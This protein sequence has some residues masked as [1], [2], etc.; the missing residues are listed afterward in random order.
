V[1][2]YQAFS[3]DLHVP[4]RDKEN[5]RAIEKAEKKYYS[6]DIMHDGRLAPRALGMYQKGLLPP[7]FKH[8]DIKYNG[9]P[10]A[11]KAA[12]EGK[13]PASFKQWSLRNDTGIPVAHIAAQYGTLPSNFTK[14]E[15]TEEVS[16]RYGYPGR[17]VASEYRKKNGENPPGYDKAINE[18]FELAL[19]ELRGDGLP[20]SFTNWA[21][22]NTKKDKSERDGG[23]EYLRTI[24]HYAAEYGKLPAAFDQWDLK[25]AQGISVE[26]TAAFYGK[27]P[28][29]FP[30]E[31]L[32]HEVDFRLEKATIAHIAAEKGCLPKDFS[33]FELKDNNGDT[34]YHYLARAGR[35][36]ESF[37]KWDLKGG[38]KTVAQVAALHGKLPKDFDALDSC[39]EEFM[40]GIRI[41]TIESRC[42]DLEDILLESK[43][44]SFPENIPE[45]LLRKEVYNGLTV[46]HFAASQ[47]QLPQDYPGW[48]DQ[49]ADMERTVAHVA[50]RAD[51]LP[52][53]FDKWDLKNA[54]G[55]T[56]AHI[57]AWHANLPATF[58][59]WEMADGEGNAVAHIAAHRGGLPEN[60]D[61]WDLKN[62]A[63][64]TVAHTAAW[65][66]KLPATFDQWEMADG[67]G[68][69]VAHIT[70]RRGGLPENFDKW[71]LKN[72]AGDTVAHVASFYCVASGWPLPK[73]LD[74]W[75]MKNA[76]GETVIEAARKIRS[77]SVVEEAYAHATA[78][79]MVSSIH[80][81]TSQ[82]SYK[83][84]AQALKAGTLPADFND[85]SK[86]NEAGWTLAHAAASIGKLPSNFKD[87]SMEGGKPGVTVAHIAMRQGMLPPNFDQWDIKDAAGKTLGELAVRHP[88]M[89]AEYRG[90]I[91][92]SST[93]QQPR[94]EAR[95]PEPQAAK[96]SQEA[97][98]IE[99][100]S[101]GRIT[102]GSRFGRPPENVRSEPEPERRPVRSVI[103]RGGL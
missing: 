9:E 68:D 75:H 32:Y 18:N 77:S 70:A 49:S 38:S 53:N 8:W 27:L 37:D 60:F 44:V 21:L 73:S 48:L 3:K 13:L 33:D 69:A 82:L 67:K 4:Y 98:K 78:N 101:I 25:T 96:P 100:S 64:E 52:E 79:A 2:D 88:T 86:K 17:N 22:A 42:V 81:S 71:D 85:W 7:D 80:G 74:D 58:D 40:R 43:K 55:E 89:G 95:S 1:S 56:V 29:S 20:S 28:D 45:E 54:A 84:A 87:W 15:I 35:L 16:M 65:H 76:A 36:P 102:G 50:A 93:T 5:K 61:K 63:G 57:A 12:R 83:E 46:A 41:N 23:S 92:A 94:T 11:F 91:Q 19:S 103:S 51:K 72:A 97:P 30:N 10:L 99:T 59:Q 47:I 90:R 6:E 24:A 62:A 26:H 31:R 66:A 14:W 39:A 34:V